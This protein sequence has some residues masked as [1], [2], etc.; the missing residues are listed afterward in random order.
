MESSSKMS[1]YDYIEAMSYRAVAAIVITVVCFGFLGPWLVSAAS[2][3]A[4]ILGITVVL[5]N[6][7]AIWKITLSA[8]RLTEKYEESQDA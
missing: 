4:V 1:K 5:L 3:P 7:A 6:A 8:I 2:T